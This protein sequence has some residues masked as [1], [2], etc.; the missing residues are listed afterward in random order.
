[1]T[2]TTTQLKQ[3]IYLI[4]NVKKEDII[5]TKKDRPFAILMDIDRYEKLMKNSHKDN[6]KSKLDA[7]KAL[8]S[9]K[10]GGQNISDIKVNL[11]EN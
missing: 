6:K 9:Y 4:D 1:M 10:L 11:Y 2:L 7:L 8:G 5:I 3:Q